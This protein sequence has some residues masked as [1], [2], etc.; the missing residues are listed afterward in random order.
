MS[1]KKAKE[2]VYTHRTE[3]YEGGELCLCSKCGITRRC[4]PNFDFYAKKVG[5]PLVCE[6]CSRTCW[7]E[8]VDKA[9]AN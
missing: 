5:D 7:Q 6:T 4:T 8:M 3:L 1:D 9:N 2:I